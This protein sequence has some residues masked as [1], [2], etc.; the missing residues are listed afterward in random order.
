MKPP[1]CADE[2]TTRREVFVGRMFEPSSTG[3]TGNAQRARELDDL[4][5]RVLAHPLRR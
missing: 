1:G 2:R 5:D 3:A 4:V